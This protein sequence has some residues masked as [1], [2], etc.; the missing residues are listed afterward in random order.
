MPTRFLC[1]HALI[2]GETGSGKTMSGIR[3][4]LDGL[5]APDLPDG[6][7]GCVLVVDPKREPWD[8]VADQGPRLNDIGAD[9][10][11]AVNVMA[12]A[13]W[14]ITADIAAGRSLA[15]AERLLMRSASLTPLNPANALAGRPS[16]G[17]N[18]YWQTDGART[19]TMAVAL[20]LAL[21]DRSADLFRSSAQSPLKDISPGALTALRRFGE[22][23][24][25]LMP[26]AELRK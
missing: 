21:L 4:L 16:A 10:D 19:A 9:G 12:G 22:R 17:H 15:A 1:R 24:G 20:T 26:H 3:P 13:D 18:Q 7:V 14:D 8:V 11:P 6:T 2:L 25:L 23:A 5:L